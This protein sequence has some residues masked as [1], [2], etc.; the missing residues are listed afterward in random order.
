MPSHV[1]IIVI[2][3]VSAAVLL[4]F[5]DRK[6]VREAS[7]SLSCNFRFLWGWNRRC[8]LLLATRTCNE[9]V[10]IPR[11][12]SACFLSRRRPR[13]SHGLFYPTR[14]AAPHRSD[15]DLPNSEDQQ[16]EQR[17]VCTPSISNKCARLGREVSVHFARTGDGKVLV[18]PCHLSSNIPQ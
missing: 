2:I 18:K 17:R 15:K 9:W 7:S 1:M 10:T 4:A 12:S 8:S 3:C 5:W 6:P 13:E 16:L 11:S 14:S